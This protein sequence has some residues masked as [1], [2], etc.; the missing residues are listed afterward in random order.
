VLQ[1]VFLHPVRL[2]PGRCS[3][4]E[5]GNEGGLV[6]L[7]LGQEEVP[8]ELVEAIP[9]FRRA[10]RLEEQVVAG[11]PPKPRQRVGTLEHRVAQRRAE[12]LEDGR[13]GE[14]RDVVRRQGGEHL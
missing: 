6:G 11:H 14:E 12:L 4:V 10:D 5:L 7:E 1:R 2:V 8:E 3:V 9:A 13:A